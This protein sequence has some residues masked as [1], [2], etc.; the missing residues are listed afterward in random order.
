MEAIAAAAGKSLAPS[1][2]DARG[3]EP[4]I[5]IRQP[6]VFAMSGQSFEVYNM[7]TRFLSTVYCLPLVLSTFASPS[8]V[9]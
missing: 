2:V 9:I 5:C 8:L 6:L 3:S 4:H 1:R 7:L